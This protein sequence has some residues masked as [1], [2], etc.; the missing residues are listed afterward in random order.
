MGNRAVHVRWMGAVLLH[1]LLGLLRMLRVPLRMFVKLS[2]LLRCTNLICLCV[3]VPL[4][5]LSFR[6][7]GIGW[8]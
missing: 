6:G 4:N 5:C 1:L 2:K 8:H 3:C 7:A